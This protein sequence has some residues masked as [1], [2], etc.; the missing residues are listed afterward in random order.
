MWTLAISLVSVMVVI[1]TAFVLYYQ[2]DKLKKE[3]NTKLQNVVNQINDSQYYEYSFDKK[4][5]QNIKNLDSNITTV[6]KSLVDLQNNVK[7]LEKNAVNKLDM[8]KNVQTELLD[9]K[10]LKSKH[11]IIANGTKQNNIVIEG[12]RTTDGANEGYSA[13]NF[14][15]YTEQGEKKIND[16][17]SRWRIASDQRSATDSFSIDQYGVDNK[18]TNYV[19]MTDG[20]VTLNNNKLRFSNKWTGWPDNAKDQAEI[21]N[22]PA[23]GKLM[24]VGNKSSGEGIRK[25]GIWDHLDVHGNQLTS[26]TSR[27][28]SIIGDDR[29]QVGNN[30]AYMRSDGYIDGVNVHASQGLSVGNNSAWMRSDGTTK[31]DSLLLGTK[32]RLAGNGDGMANDSWLRLTDQTGKK[33]YGGIATNEL[34]AENQL[35]IGGTCI[36]KADLLKVKALK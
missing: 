18:L 32:W 13:I 25:V 4:Q 14:N 31:T 29:V 6:N 1:T 5:E 26:G 3:T 10:Y 30:T 20:S 12:G 9:S 34:W 11:A 19:W 28:K 16:K 15:G 21:S 22:D 23:F 2:N 17:K 36:T 35:C 7:F 8:S 24:I 33:Y 27:A